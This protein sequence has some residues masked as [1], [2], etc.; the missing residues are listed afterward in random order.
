MSI[1][2]EGV[3][4]NSFRDLEDLDLAK[5][6]D[7]RVL[8]VTIDGVIWHTRRSSDL[9]TERLLKLYYFMVLTRAVDRE[10]VKLS[11]KGLAFGKHLMCTGN[12]A[13][14]VGAAFALDRVDWATLA[15]RD[16]GVFMVRGVAPVQIL[17]QA[18]GRTTGLTGGWDGSLHMGSRAHRIAGLV[19]HLG[20]LAAIGVGCAFAERYK[21]TSGAALAFIGE[22]STSTGDVHEALN[23]ASVLQLPVVLVVENNQ[24][25]FGTPQRLQ[26][27]VPTMALRALAY[28]A[29]VEG[30]CVDGTD[31]LSVYH[32]VKEALERARTSHT[33]SI[34]ETVSMRLEGHSLADP[35]TR[36]VPAAQLELWK[37]RDPIARLRAHLLD[38]RLA[39]GEELAAVD[40]R[41][42]DEVMAAAMEAEAGPTP[43]AEDIEA[44]VFQ[45]SPTPATSAVIPS[46]GEATYYHRAIHDGL[47]EEMDRD[48][49]LFLIGEDIGI[50]DGAFKITEGFSKRYDGLD[51]NDYWNTDV[52]FAQR[53]VLDAPIAEAGFSGLAL[54]A[55]LAG[56]RAVVEFQYADFASEAFK[57]IVNYTATQTVRRMGP[58]PIVFRMP[59]GW[60]PNTSLYHSVNPESW[61][62]STPG[63]KIVAPITAYD[64]KGLLKAAIRD[65]NP[66]LFLEYKAHYRTAPKNLPDVLNVPVPAEDYVVPIGCARVVLPGSDLSVI[67]YGSQVMRAV[68]AAEQLQREDGASVEVIDLRTLVPYDRDCVRTSV[69]KTG[70]ALVTCEAPRTGAFGNTIVTEVIRSCFHC[71]D[72]PVWLVA[73][74]DT[75]VPFAPA[76]EE[77]HLPTTKKLVAAI[78]SVLAY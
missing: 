4:V 11:R 2:M 26:Y 75:P 70:R 29:N 16:L 63:L 8:Q 38:K 57:M 25:A 41:V 9:S 21:G 5:D 77:A 18:C 55:V 14:A 19:S 13:S 23:I 39:S 27:A 40:R 73:A 65:G 43:T 42:A 1:V 28:G 7:G 3:V 72:A 34:I 56:L 64:A 44:G 47:Q 30:Y 50:S 37:Q 33:I 17:A 6:L 60:A 59:S 36:Y 24:W 35:F 31:V 52:T 62:A 53:R 61:F 67:T 71:L 12:E 32:T 54:G 22:G 49:T 68:A 15:I 78:R 51:W 20:T 74:A 10:I 45:T 76:L 48:P 46:G 66:V 69:E 58:V